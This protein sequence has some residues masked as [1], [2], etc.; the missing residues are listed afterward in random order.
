MDAASFPGLCRAWRRRRRLSQLDLALTAGISQRHLSCLETGRSRPSPAMVLRLCEALEVPLRDRN[1]LLQAAG[2]AP[3]YRESGL[4]AKDMAP[5]RQALERLLAHHEPLPAFVLDRRW[6]VLGANRAATGLLAR[7]GIEPAAGE[8]VNL[9]RATLD[10][11]GLGA[12]IVNRAEVTAHL[13]ERLRREAMASADP[14]LQRMLEALEAA[15]PQPPA[16]PGAETGLLP[17]LPLVIDAGDRRL[18]LFTVVSTFGTAQDVT[19][20]EMRIETLYPA[21]AGTAAFFGA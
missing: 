10:P 18:S 1:L 5:V 15:P 21:D 4:E 7:L 14:E 3:R 2:F 20:E 11:A 19:A 16:C 8:T 13:H 9:V 17:V 12:A 6:N